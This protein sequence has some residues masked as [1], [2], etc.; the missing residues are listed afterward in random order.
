MT[1]CRFVWNATFISTASG[2]HPSP[3][4]RQREG[5]ESPSAVRVV[6]QKPIGRQRFG[7]RCGAAGRVKAK[8]FGC[9]T[10]S[11]DPP[12]CPKATK[13]LDLLF[14]TRNDDGPE[15]STRVIPLP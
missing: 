14:S 8:P 9:T 11:L 5:G 1:L 6:G 7:E 12:V 10:G 15:R 4:S 2:G 3:P 13:N